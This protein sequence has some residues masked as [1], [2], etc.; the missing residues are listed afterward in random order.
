MTHGIA[1]N[2]W[3]VSGVLDVVRVAPGDRPLHAAPKHHSR[4][5]C[6][7]FGFGSHG[8]SG[9]QGLSRRTTSPKRKSFS[10]LWSAAVAG[11]WC[12]YRHCVRRGARTSGM[13]DRGRN[14][15]GVP[16]DF[17]HQHVGH[18]GVPRSS[19]AYWSFWAHDAWF[20]RR[21]DLRPDLRYHHAMAWC[22]LGGDRRVVC[23]FC[24]RLV[25]GVPLAKKSVQD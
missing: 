6:R 9:D 7:V 19:G 8:C 13:D 25:S 21:L 10:W 17:P 4:C 5:R 12:W 15:F 11:R 24:L 1:G 14:G 3:L 16:S 2:T 18:L 20:G 22:S 23:G